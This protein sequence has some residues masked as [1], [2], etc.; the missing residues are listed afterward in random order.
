MTPFRLLLAMMFAALAL[1]TAVSLIA[2][3]TR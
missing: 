2:N 3:L 1:Y